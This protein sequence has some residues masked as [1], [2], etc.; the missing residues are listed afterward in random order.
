MHKS[1]LKPKPTLSLTRGSNNDDV[2][3]NEG[4]EVATREDPKKS[5]VKIDQFG[6]I[7]FSNERTFLR[8]LNFVS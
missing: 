2:E 3:D 4:A 1:I 7:Y 8:W 6:K 5:S